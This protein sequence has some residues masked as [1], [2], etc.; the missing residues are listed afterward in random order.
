MRIDQCNKQALYDLPI[1]DSQVEKVYYDYGHRQI[2]FSCRNYFSQKRVLFTFHNVIFS[3]MN[4]CCFPYGTARIYEVY[5]QENSAEFNK[6]M[7]F[8]DTK[9]D[10]YQGSFLD[11][12][13]EY[14]PVQFRM[15]IKDAL[16]IICQSID[17]HEESL[18]I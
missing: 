9:P 5:L 8:K 4:N 11:R 14:L 6:L 18:D 16:I 13:I 2:L 12:G 3:S 10:W 15:N 1:H 17:V 7:S